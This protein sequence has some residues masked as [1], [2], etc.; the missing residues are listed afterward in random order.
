M[1]V[2]CLIAV[3]LAFLLSGGSDGHVHLPGPIAALAPSGLPSLCPSEAI[4]GLRC[5]GCGMTRAFVAM[6]EL[7]V[8]DA[9]RLNW[10]GPL[11]FLM[12][13]FSIP[14]RIYLI[15]ARSPRPWTVSPRLQ[16]LGYTVIFLMFA[17]WLFDIL[18]GHYP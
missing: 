16:W 11:F 8:A 6:A 9:W 13:L 3:G 12:A 18:S 10:G 5:P 7:R 4:F 15:R 1:L 17:G 14:H 2:Y